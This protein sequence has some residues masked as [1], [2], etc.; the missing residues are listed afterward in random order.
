MR[1]MVLMLPVEA[2]PE[3]RVA[4]SNG[5]MIDLINRRKIAP[6]TLSCFAG[7][8]SSVPNTIPATR[9]IM[10]QVVSDGFFIGRPTAVF[11]AARQRKESRQG[12]S[13]AQYVRSGG[14]LRDRPYAVVLL[15]GRRR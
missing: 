11:R 10:I 12:G 8:G 13:I 3:T 9:P 6:S 1:P 15:P 14:I 7:P 2:I 5:A 4:N